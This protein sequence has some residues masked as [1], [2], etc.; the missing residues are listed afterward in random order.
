MVT[1]KASGATAI[2]GL[3]RLEPTE[4]FDAGPMEPEEK[5]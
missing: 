5:A 4:V 1:G 3:M 2:G